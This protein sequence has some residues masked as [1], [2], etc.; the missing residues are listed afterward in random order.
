VAAEHFVAAV[1]EDFAVAAEEG[2]EAAEAVVV[3]AGR[4]STSSTTWCSSVGLT[5]VS[6]T[7]AS[8]TTATIGPT[9]G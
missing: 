6:V 9:S 4:I 2:F 8:H 5:T 1:V 3:D 7:T